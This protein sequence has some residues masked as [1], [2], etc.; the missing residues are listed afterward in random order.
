VVATLPHVWTVPTRGSDNGQPLEA[1]PVAHSQQITR[2]GCELLYRLTLSIFFA[3]AARSV[4]SLSCQDYLSQHSDTV[5][6]LA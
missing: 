4:G 3:A 1:L 5:T 6:V 2:N